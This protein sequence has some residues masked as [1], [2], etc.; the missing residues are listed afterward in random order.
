MK[1]SLAQGQSS[2]PVAHLEASYPAYC[3]SLRILIRDGTPL[4]K[5]KRTACWRG[6]ELLHNDCPEKYEEPFMSY[7]LIKEDM[8]I[9]LKSVA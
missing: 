4:G 7:R 2:R 1:T 9:L 3:Q 8:A 5:I 6:L